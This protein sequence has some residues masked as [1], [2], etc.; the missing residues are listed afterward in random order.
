MGE[1][2]LLDPR[3]ELIDRPGEGCAL[4]VGVSEMQLGLKL[5]EADELLA[6]V[7]GRPVA[8]DSALVWAD[9]LVPEFGGAL[10]EKLV[11][12]R[13]IVQTAY[14]PVASV[15]AR[16]ARARPLVAVQSVL[17]RQPEI[18]ATGSWQE[19]V[20]PG[21][22][23]LP[24][25]PS[26]RAFTPKQIDI[27]VL[28]TILVAGYG[29]LGGPVLPTGRPRRSVP[30]AGGIY[31]FTLAVWRRP[32]SGGVSSVELFDPSGLSLRRTTVEW[33]ATALPRLFGEEFLG[34]VGAIVIFLADLEAC[35]SKY[36]ERAYRFVALEAGHISQA[37]IDAAQQQNLGCL[38]LGSQDDEVLAEIFQPLEPIHALAIGFRR[39]G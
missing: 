10:L 33:P 26:C 9:Q 24:R 11:S 32:T 15:Y 20:A 35:A 34:D 29:V 31:P 25:W 7:R 21:A 14:A 23:N 37:M 30:S 16:T 22:Q 39:D 8:R 27:E 3:A 36:G 19:R 28:S 38:C 1:W 18:L 17:P 4:R 2:W 12:L 5:A 6:L 13:M